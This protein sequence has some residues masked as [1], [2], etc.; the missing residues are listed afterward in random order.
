MVEPVSATAVATSPSWL[1][2][3][4]AGLGVAGGLAEGFLTSAKSA[5]EARKNRNFQERMSNTAHQREVKDLLAAGLNPILSAKLGGSST[6]P[7]ATGQVPEFNATGKGIA[8]AQAAG[9]LKLL[10]AQIAD[11]NE[12][13]NLKRFQSTDI[14][15]TQATRIDALMGQYRRDLEAAG[16]SIEQKREIMQKILNLKK[17]YE[18]LELQRKHSAYGINEAAA[19]S[20]FYDSMGGDVSVWAKKLGLDKL[21]PGSGNLFELF[22]RKGGK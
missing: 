18:I 12:A 14:S 3:A 10:Q 16:V 20:K 4:S 22:K 5:S 19:N 6:P 8:A 2:I 9:Q 15:S 7:G 17:E 21:I 13:A 1:P 11:T